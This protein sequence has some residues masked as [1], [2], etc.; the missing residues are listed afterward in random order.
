MLAVDHDDDALDVLPPL[1]LPFVRRA[2]APWGNPC[3]NF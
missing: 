2:T 3:K 1:V